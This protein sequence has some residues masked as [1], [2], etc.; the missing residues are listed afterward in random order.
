MTGK[1]DPE[2]KVIYSASG[3]SPRVAVA[4]AA[5]AESPLR[6][7]GGGV[8]LLALLQFAF[9]GASAYLAWNQINR[10]LFVA[11]IMKTPVSIDQNHIEALSAYF[12]RAQAAAGEPAPTAAPTTAP[13]E[14][15]PKQLPGEVRQALIWGSL[16]VWLAVLSASSCFLMLS[17][18]ASFSAA[19]AGRTRATGMLL[20][21]LGLLG[22]VGGAA[23]IWLVYKTGFPTWAA[24]AAVGIL[25]VEALGIGM[26]AGRRYI[27]LLRLAGLSVIAAAAITT[28]GIYAWDRSG[29]DPAEYLPEAVAAWQGSGDGTAAPQ[30]STRLLAV[31]FAA[32][33][34]FGWVLLLAGV[35]RRGRR[36]AAAANA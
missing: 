11:A 3:G 27:G 17:G 29:I 10:Q 14:A 18:G 31:A 4:P 32:H 36:P 1:S 25:M 2:V 12:N 33:S 20:V 35:G 30:A 13:A 26:L 8:L 34:L 24:Q 9:A 5:S 16:H 7:A 22:L 6:R 28:A 19:L 21:M 15:P 23:A